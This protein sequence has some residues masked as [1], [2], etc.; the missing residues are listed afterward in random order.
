M[1][2]SVLVIAFV[3]FVVI[4]I[5]CCIQPT[6]ESFYDGLWTVTT[7]DGIVYRDM[8]IRT[9]KIPGLEAQTLMG[10]TIYIKDFFRLERSD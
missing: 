8:K 9:A 7:K 4:L 2:K 5:C 3:S 1:K 10:K 6:P